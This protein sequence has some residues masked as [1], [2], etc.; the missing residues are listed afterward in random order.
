MN[1]HNIVIAVTRERTSR[2]DVT[3]AFRCAQ[4]I[5][6]VLKRQYHTLIIG[7]TKKDLKN[8]QA[9]TIKLKTYSPVCVFNLFEG[10]SDDSAKEIEFVRLLESLKI[11]FTGNPS[12]A[13]NNCLNKAKTAR[14]LR[15]HKISAPK[16]RAINKLSDIRLKNIKFPVFIKP[17]MEDAS[18]GIDGDSLVENKDDLNRILAKKLKCFRSG[19]MVEEFIFGKEYNVGFLSN[20]DDGCVGISVIDYKKYSRF[21]P[22]LTYD[23]KWNNKVPEFKAIRPSREEKLDKRLRES[24]IDISQRSAKALG[25]IGYF[26]VDIREKEGK[27][28]VLDVNPNPDINIDGGFMRQAL[29]GGVKFSDMVR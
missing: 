13:L 7:I 2:R 29:V 12:Y 25:C 8:I 4:K 26:R 10:F 9:L 5:S 14:I 19:V 28:Y 21:R 27:L 1:K 6:K 3:D 15:K 17:L 16:G 11:P 24:I 23:S 22:F 18:I 20:N